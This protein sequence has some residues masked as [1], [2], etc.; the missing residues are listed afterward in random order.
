MGRRRVAETTLALFLNVGECLAVRI[1][2]TYGFRPVKVKTV[3][4]KNS[5]YDFFSLAAL[6][7][8]ERP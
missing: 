6:T 1:Q 2:I 4:L 7:E 3:T 5:H 8:G